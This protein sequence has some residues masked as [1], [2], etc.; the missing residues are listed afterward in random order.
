MAWTHEQIL[1]EA[2]A[3]LRYARS[4]VGDEATAEDLVQDALVAA[5][6]QPPDGPEVPLR[7]WLFATLRH[8]VWDHYRW[9]RRHPA[10]AAPV[11][12]AS[13]EGEGGPY[14]FDEHGSWQSDPN[15]GLSPLDSADPAERRQLRSD[16]QRCLDGLPQRLHDV[17]VLRELDDATADHVAEALGL[18]RE[19]VAV[20]LYRARQQLRTCL[21]HHWGA[22]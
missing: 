17:F 16:L 14:G 10:D 3:L 15:R 21:Q 2:P 20:F 8:K 11:D 4:R 13:H 1:A 7:A 6:L 5:V 19:S 22:P 9:K 18:A 12:H